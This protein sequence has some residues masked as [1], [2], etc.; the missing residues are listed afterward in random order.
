[1]FALIKTFLRQQQPVKL[2]L[3]DLSSARTSCTSE[4]VSEQWSILYRKT[5]T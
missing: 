5:S 4:L 3:L 2:G 1:M